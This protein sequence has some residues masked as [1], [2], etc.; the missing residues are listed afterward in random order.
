M[1]PTRAEQAEGTRAALVSA[2]RGMFAAKGFAG[3][4]TNDVIAAAGVT[5][6]ALYHHFPAKEDLFRAVYEAVQSDFADG[7]ARG[8]SHGADPIDQLRLGIGAFFDLSLTDEVQRIVMVDAPSV[9]GWETWRE[10][11]AKYGLALIRTGLDAAAAAGR[12]ERQPTEL[13][14]HMLLAAL[15]E[16]ALYLA[17][18]PNP[19]KRKPEVVA[20][21]LRL[22]DNIT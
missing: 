20:S 14:A 1:T 22:L 12:I 3:T 19:K 21:A 13:L 11:D 15:N 2:A 18:V 10:I 16:A 6:G 5:R 9:L 8:A 4:A 17:R 7:I